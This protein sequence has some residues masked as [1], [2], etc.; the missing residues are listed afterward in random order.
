MLFDVSFT[1]RSATSDD[2]YDATVGGAG[3]ISIPNNGTTA[4]LTIPIREDTPVSYTHLT[5]PTICSV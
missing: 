5:L 3:V 1:D 4:S 2:D